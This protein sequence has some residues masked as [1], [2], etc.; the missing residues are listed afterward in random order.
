MEGKSSLISVIQQKIVFAWKDW[1]PKILD[2]VFINF[3]V[4]NVTD[5]RLVGASSF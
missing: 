1:G 2:L 4:F 5:Y 3:E